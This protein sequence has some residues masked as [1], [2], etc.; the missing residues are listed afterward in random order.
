MTHEAYCEDFFKPA[1]ENVVKIVEQ[2]SMWSRKSYVLY[3]TDVLNMLIEHNLISQVEVE[4][5]VNDTRQKPLDL[6][7]P[8]R[9]IGE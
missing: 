9:Y 5:I 6:T 7:L 8:Q 3:P 1:N 2:I 4:K